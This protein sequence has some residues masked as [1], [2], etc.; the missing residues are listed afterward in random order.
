MHYYA[1]FTVFIAIKIHVTQRDVRFMSMAL[2]LE[3][4]PRERE[5]VG[6]N[7]GRDGPKSLELVVVAFALGAQDYGNSTTTDLPVLR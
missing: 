4:P 6:F 3:R 5:V 2:R 7:L 1:V